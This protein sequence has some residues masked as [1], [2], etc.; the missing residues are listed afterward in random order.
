MGLVM[1]LGY[2]H[3]TAVGISKNIRM[4]ERSVQT[5][6]VHTVECCKSVGVLPLFLLFDF[7]FET[8]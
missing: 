5:T 8:I 1:T 7:A 3:L 4:T 2:L 6:N